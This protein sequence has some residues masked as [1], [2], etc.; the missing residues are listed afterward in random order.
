MQELL[1]VAGLGKL[2][3]EEFHGFDRRKRIKHLT[4]NPGALE[5]FLRD[6][7]LFLTRAGT[8]DVNGREDTFID[9]LAVQNDFP[10]CR[11]P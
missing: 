7:Q 5:I 6:Q 11:Y 8:L 2:I 4:K 9:K 3:G 10:C 1:I